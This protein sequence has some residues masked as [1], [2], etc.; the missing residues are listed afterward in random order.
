M[1]LSILVV[2]I[3]TNIWSILWLLNFVWPGIKIEVNGVLLVNFVI[4]IGLSVEFCLHIIM[5][6][7]RAN[8]DK[9]TR[10]RKTITD[11]V[12]VVFK[13]IFI[14]KLLGLSVLGFSP[15]PLFVLYYFRVYYVMIL[16]CAFYGLLVTPMILDIFGNLVIS[17]EKVQRRRLMSLNEYIR[18]NVEN[19]DDEADEEA[20]S[21]RV[22]R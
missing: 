18:A 6:F 12:S 13:G 22:I 1:I 4:C 7:M 15:I 21:S 17:K 19:S 9:D 14:T 8:G 2:L 20:D 10:L 5:R 11:V 3:S 16:V